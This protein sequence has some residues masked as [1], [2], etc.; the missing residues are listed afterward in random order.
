[1]KIT[2]NETPSTLKADINTTLWGGV[3]KKIAPHKLVR[4]LFKEDSLTNWRNK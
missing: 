1:M 4:L 2:I 3:Y